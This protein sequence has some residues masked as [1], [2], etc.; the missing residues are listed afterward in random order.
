MYKEIIKDFQKDFLDKKAKKREIEFSFDILKL[1]K[2]IT[3]IWPRRA[4]KTYFMFYI[5]DKLIKD[6]FLELEQIVFID[7]SAFIDKDFDIK[8][9]LE[10]FYALYPY[11]EPFFIFDEIQELENF[12]KIILY[13]FNK[14]YKIFLSWSN[15]KL[16]SSE[17]STEFRWRT[18]DIKVFPLNFSEF[19]YFKNIEKIDLY[20]SKQ[21]WFLQN[22]YLE[23]LQFWAYPEIV[24]IDNKNIKFDLLKAYFE[25]VLYK[26]LLERYWVENEYVLK[27]LFKKIILNNTKEFSISK[28]FNE[29]KSQNIKIWIQTLYNYLE[30]FK[31]IFFLS[32]INDKY[33]KIWKKFYLYDVWFTNLIDKNN[34]WQRFENVVYISLLRK[35]WDINYI[36]NNWEIDFVLEKEDLAIQVCFDLNIENIDRELK[37]LEKSNYKNKILIYFNTSK[38]FKVDWINILNIFEFEKYLEWVEKQKNNDFNFFKKIT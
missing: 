37:Q 1:N 26:D 33:K 17:L 13:L 19:L 20:T 22:T 7:F 18:Y 10:N 24:L 31:E 34:L 25:I 21:K 12:S 27:Y 36:N 35:Y 9:L 38:D 4:W 3:F 11:K 28:V 16:L 2:I 32:E 23:Y 30:Y 5:L 14:N 29:L 8:K 15:S 6:E